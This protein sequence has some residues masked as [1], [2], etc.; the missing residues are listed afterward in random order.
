MESSLNANAAYLSA[1]STIPKVA[2]ASVVAPL[3]P[4]INPNQ[5]VPNLAA[6]APSYLSNIPSSVRNSLSTLA[7]NPMN[8]INYAKAL[9]TDSAFVSAISAL[10]TAVPS[11][12]QKQLNTDPL[13]F[14]Q[15][16]IAA[17]SAP[18][19]IKSLPTSVQQ[20][21]G[22]AMTKGLGTKTSSAAIKPTAVGAGVAKSSGSSRTGYPRSSGT[23]YAR[24][25]GTG[26]QR[27]SG[28]GYPRSSGTG[29]A[30][31]TGYARS[32][33]T[34]YPRASG[35]GVARASGTDATRGGGSSPLSFKG[36]AVRETV[37]S[38]ALLSVFAVIGV[39]FVA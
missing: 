9:A 1:I 14:F 5:F 28:T 10:A 25:S 32:S 7:A 4:I 12:V 31:S 13:D 33:G 37:G 21:L 17:S 38:V 34:G 15:T 3:S 22:T 35:T 11:S 19:Y 16:A 24:S 20:R 30:R 6:P 2:P 8:D 27:S 23:G 26:Y 18:A 39:L 36:A 29:V